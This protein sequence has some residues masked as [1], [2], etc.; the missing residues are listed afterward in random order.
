MR[1]RLRKAKRWRSRRSP[2]RT[3]KAVQADYDKLAFNKAVARIYELVNALAAP[4]AKVAAGEADA[5]YRSAVREAVEILIALVAPM[6]PHLAEECSAAARQ[7]AS[8]RHEQ[9]G[10]H[11]TKRSSSRTRSCYPVQINGKK[12][13]ELTIARDADQNAVQERRTGP[14][15]RQKRIEWSGAEED[16]RRSAEDREHCRLIIFS[17][18]LA[19]QASASVIAAAGLFPPARSGRFMPRALAKPQK[20][21]D[22]STFPTPVRASSRQFAIN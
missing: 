4:L 15:C 12:R 14:G 5:A 3:L 21:A 6:T 13:A 8:G 11:T 10:R 19:L 22:R 9:L 18:S 7:H 20:L 1:R 2:T 16:H 17:S